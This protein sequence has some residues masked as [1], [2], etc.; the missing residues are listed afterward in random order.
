MNP[1]LTELVEVAT[2][3][4]RSLNLQLPTSAPVPGQSV[5]EW[6]KE[7]AV[8]RKIIDNMFPAPPSPPFNGTIEIIAAS[9][10]RKWGARLY[11]PLGTS[12][13]RPAVV[14]FHGGG[15]WMAGGETMANVSDPICQLLAEHLGAV[16]LAVDYRLAPEF[17]YPAAVEDCQDSFDWLV[18]SATRL[19][20][21]PARIA[22][23]GVSSGG[24]MAA[25]TALRV[26]AGQTS[27]PRAVVLM[28]PALDLTGLKAMADVEHKDFAP[29][30]VERL[31]EN[32]LPSGTNRADPYVSP[33]LAPDL[34][35]F[36]PTFI[37]VGEYDM[38]RDQGIKFASRLNDA[39]I[40]AQARRYEMTHGIAEPATTQA[41]NDDVLKVL[42]NAFSET[43]GDPA[44]WFVG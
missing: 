7:V 8:L 12:T 1:E 17:K 32:Y 21:D 28:V 2:K 3:I 20:V 37:V 43:S 44:T 9:A 42:R 14:V 36:P 30:V 27:H 34:S 5:E 29:D 31:Y 33:G 39:G 11:S 40:P 6:G 24:N 18:N 10:E 25:V 35:G 13:N 22:L 38:L 19:G 41:F 4:V 26:V 15:F 16:I 23:Y